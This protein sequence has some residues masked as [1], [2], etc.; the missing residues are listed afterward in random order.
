MD[1][2]THSRQDSKSLMRSDQ[3]QPSEREDPAAAALRSGYGSRLGEE[4]PPAVYES[5]IIAFA[6]MLAAAWLAFGGLV[7]TDL[8]LIVVTVL[9]TIFLTLPIV[10][11][12]T[13]AVPSQMR[14][15]D[16]K[17]FLSS[18]FETATGSL[19]A[20]EAWLQVALIPVALAAAATL[21]GVVY[22]WFG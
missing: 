1:E 17:H 2:N 11:Y 9:C 10:M 5:V 19:P 7:G 20:G 18:R 12:R 8:D 21:I 3:G 16:L 22:L 4:F 13:N 6:W 14:Q 15:L